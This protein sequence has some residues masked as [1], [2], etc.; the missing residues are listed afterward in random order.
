VKF[1]HWMRI[2]LNY[3][4]SFWLSATRPSSPLSQLL[5]LPGGSTQHSVILKVVDDSNNSNDVKIFSFIDLIR[6]HLKQGNIN[7]N[8]S[9]AS[10]VMNGIMSTY[11]SYDL[12]EAVSLGSEDC[13]HLLCPRLG[14]RFSGHILFRLFIPLSIQRYG[15]LVFINDISK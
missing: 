4:L 10:N 8:E 12:Y 9:Y 15:A 5:V 2:V 13:L 6:Y 3:V 1:D 14:V 7:H 11:G